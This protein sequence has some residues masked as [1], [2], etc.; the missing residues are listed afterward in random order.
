MILEI[1][2]HIPVPIKRLNVLRH[3]NSPLC[4]IAKEIHD[5]GHVY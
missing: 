2:F 4:A 1:N 3:V 5:K